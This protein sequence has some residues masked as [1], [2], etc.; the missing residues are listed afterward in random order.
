MNILKLLTLPVMIL[1]VSV[2]C[3]N[4]ASAQRLV[5]FHEEPEIYLL[6]DGVIH[7]VPDIATQRQMGLSQAPFTSYSRQALGLAQLSHPLPSLANQ[8]SPS[9]VKASNDDRVYALING[10]KSHV[11]DMATLASLKLTQPIVTLPAP[12]IAVIPMGHPF[13][14]IKKYDSLRR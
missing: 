1:C 11:P 10:R 3:G 7:H 5:K 12:A 13:V 9:L 2:A 8:N 14:S 4:T 6:I